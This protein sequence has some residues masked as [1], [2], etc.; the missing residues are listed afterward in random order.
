MS[1]SDSESLIVLIHAEPKIGKTRLGLTT[2]APRLILDAENGARFFV[3]K[4]ERVYWNPITEAPPEPGAWTTCIVLVRD[5]ETMKT[6]FDWLNS[7]QHSFRSVTI[8][9]ITE[10]QKRCKDS[11]IGTDDVVTERQWGQMLVRMERLIRDYRD[12]TMHPTRPLDAVVMLAL[13]TDKNGKFRPLIQGALG[14]SITGFVDV[15]GYLAVIENED[16][17]KTRRMLVSPH[18]LFEAG[19]RTGV[20]EPL[21]AI[22]SPSIESMFNAT[23]DYLKERG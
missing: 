16:G 18:P 6:A 12:L 23:N 10:I 1:E 19:D 17:T 5:F 22:D 9:S 15:I 3:K 4:S 11:I 13:T 21:G 8:D 20:F 14:L 2:P 7:G